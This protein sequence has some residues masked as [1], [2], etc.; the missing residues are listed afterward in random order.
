MEYNPYGSPMGG[1]YEVRQV[2]AFGTDPI[3]A[4][5]TS[6]GVQVPHVSPTVALL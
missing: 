4:V 1:E 5:E 2:I 6:G 3:D